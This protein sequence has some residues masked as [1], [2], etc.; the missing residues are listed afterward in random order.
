MSCE[1]P[2]VFCEDL[3]RPIS[4]EI[5]RVHRES[6]RST[7]N[8][9]TCSFLVPLVFPILIVMATVSSC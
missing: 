7:K 5:S 2:A 6:A 9:R 1:D 8:P 3:Q 4:P